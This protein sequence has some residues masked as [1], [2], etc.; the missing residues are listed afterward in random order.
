V[1][2][3]QTD[4]VATITVSVRADS[5]L[6]ARTLES[7]LVRAGSRSTRTNDRGDAILQ[8]AAGAHVIVVTK[9]GFRPDTIAITVR[10]SIDTTVIAVL[11]EE[12]MTVD[13][14]IVS[15]T[16][17]ERRVEDTPLRVETIDDEELA[18]KVAMAPGD[19]G[20]LLNETGGL[21]VQ[22]TNPSLGGA[23]VRIQGLR[24]RYSL[25]LADGLPLY[26][27][28]TGGLGLL[29]IPPIDL[30]RVEIIKGTASAL[31]GSSALGGVI[32]LIS[33]RPSDDMERTLLVNQTSRNGSDAA[34]FFSGPAFGNTGATL[35]ASANRQQR[36]DIDG[37]GWT[38]LPGYS[39]AVV[40]PRL[41]FDNHEG[42][43]AFVTAGFT[44]E[45]REGGTLTG[46]VTPS[47]T[48]YEES[49]QTRRADIGALA[50]W[51]DVGDGKLFG[52]TALHDGI[53]TVRGSGVEQRHDHML[54]TVAEND[55]HRTWFGEAALALP[56]GPL[57]YV[58]G[59]AFQQETYTSDQ[60]ARFDYTFNIPSAFA[61]IDIDAARW[62]SLSTSV[63][64][65]QHSEYGT[66]VN[67]RVSLLFRAP[68]Q[69]FLAGW[70]ARVSGGTGAFAPTPLVE[71]TEV[72][73]LTPLRPL[74]SLVAERATSGSLDIGGPVA[75]AFGEM[76]VQATL[77]GSR[78]TRPLQIVSTGETTNSVIAPLTLINATG[79]TRT[80]G[81]ELLARVVRHLGDDEESPA[82]RMTASYTM[83]NA[84]ECEAVDPSVLQLLASPCARRD[85]AL[86]PRHSVGVVTTIEQEGKSRLGLELYYTGQQRLEDNPFRSESK[87]YLIVG[88]M[89]EYAV[90]TRAGTARVFLNFE[91]LTNV[92]Q[93]NF[94][95]L[96]LPARGMGGRWTTDAWTDLAGFTVNG[97]VRF[98]W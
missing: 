64:A 84:T 49:L 66:F 59:A 81:T 39:R 91:N 34:F 98:I 22:A 74:A 70:T 38:D 8:L 4:A 61:Q 75:A 18:E 93:S 44:A 7:A 47:G 42:R 62:L 58:I 83:L 17:S 80:W 5:L 33:R 6:S 20:M 71:E 40:R 68:A 73:G 86:S 76:E 10:A 15:S 94:D 50:R 53:F 51:V 57:T 21:R 35:L 78:V 96:L 72:T 19:I 43:T 63:R 92:R 48:A 52:I 31:Y 36:T 25:M 30:G 85:V 27:G 37:D 55:R 1:A 82:I 2:Q 69:P 12:P 13:A 67:P 89:G 29:Q 90:D 77:F 60:V 16:R 88:L 32:D 26:G 95:P 45:E 65:D 54:G 79:P 11:A 14:M 3:F 28:Q 24:G 23:N 56:R 97:G 87:P 9:L 41:F 46:R